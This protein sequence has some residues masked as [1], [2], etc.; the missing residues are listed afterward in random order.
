MARF[1]D[2]SVDWAQLASEGGGLTKVAGNFEPQAS[3]RRALRAEGFDPARLRRYAVFPFDVCWCYWTELSPLWNRPRPALVAQAWAGNRFIIARPSARRPD[4][5]VPVYATAALPDHH[6]L[7]PN[8]VAIPFRLRQ[9]PAADTGPA[10]QATLPLLEETPRANLSPAARRYLDAL[11]MEGCDLDAGIAAAPWLHALAV[12]LSPRYLAENADGVRR[13]YPRVPLPAAADALRASAD[14]GAEVAALMDTEV[15]VPGVTATPREELRLVGVLAVLG[16]EAIEP[17]RHLAVRAG[18]GRRAGD[19]PVM[20]GHGTLVERGY[21]DEES[22]AIEAGAARLG[23]E[24]REALALL[25]GSTFDVYLNELVYWRN[26]P[27][28][29]WRYTVGGYQV[30]K[31]WLSYREDG[32]LGRPL[33]RDEAREVTATSRR[34]AA[35]LLLQPRLDRNYDD[36]VAA[37]YEWRAAGDASAAAT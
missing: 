8:V 12:I 37:P 26:I 25:G 19:G 21:S 16:G 32:V 28:N 23:I 11:G 2:G 30:L 10:E 17:A 20:P 24:P 33:T 22:Q 4:E 36:A 6:L 15:V 9:L 7:D 14:L 27:A 1:Y 35:L 34:I 18:W 29:V 3:R 5:G 13:G 31:K